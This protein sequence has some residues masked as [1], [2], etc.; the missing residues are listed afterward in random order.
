MKPLSFGA[1]A[2]LCG[3]AAGLLVVATARLA[4]ADDRYE[5]DRRG[6]W[7]ERQR[8]DRGWDRNDRGRWEAGRH[9]EERRYREP[10]VYDGPPAGAYPPP[11]YDPRPVPLLNFNFPFYVR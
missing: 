6:G 5:H 1:H 3:V 4:S 11:A 2:M 10:Y 9:G 7:H 8:D